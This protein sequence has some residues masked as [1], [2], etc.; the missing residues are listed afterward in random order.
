MIVINNFY[1][2]QEAGA[3]VESAYTANTTGESLFVEITGDATAFEIE[4]KG[5]VDFQNEDYVN[6]GGVN[7]TSYDY[8]STIQNK[9][10]FLFPIEGI[11]RVKLNLKSV[12]G[13]VTA[14]CRVV[15]G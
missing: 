12:T 3:P 6:L 2:L 11:G 4:V 1:A 10:I 13:T 7:L 14:F 9:G 15:K 5:V 8:V